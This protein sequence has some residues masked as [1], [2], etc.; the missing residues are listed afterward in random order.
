[1][2]CPSIHPHN[3]T[4]GRTYLSVLG[5]SFL[6]LPTKTSSLKEA[7]SGVGNV[8]SALLSIKETPGA[9]DRSSLARVSLRGR[10]NSKLMLSA[11]AL[12]MGTLMHVAVMLTSSKDQIFFVS[13]TILS[14]SSLYPFSCMG[15][16]WEK[17]LKAY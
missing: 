6:I 3:L 11:W 14:S 13:F 1:M 15:E 16:L 2:P 4:L 8:F 12:M 10:S 9:V 5:M 17:R 7:S